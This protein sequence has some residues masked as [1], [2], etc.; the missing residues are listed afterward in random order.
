MGAPLA[1]TTVVLLLVKSRSLAW[2]GYRLVRGTRPL[3]ATPGL[4][5]ARV[6]GSGTGGGFTLQ[7]SATRGGLFCVF[8]SAKAAVAFVEGSATLAEYARN[9]AELG[10][11]T[12][13]PYNCRGRWGGA[14][15][16]ASEPAPA[17][18]AVVAL[19]RASIHPLRAL[20]FWRHAPPAQRAVE[21]AVGC[22]LAVGLGEAPLLRQATVS[23]WDDVHAMDA[24]ARAGAHQQ[25][26]LAA[27][28]GRH[29]SESMFVRF[30][31]VGA[32]GLWKGRPLV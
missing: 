30:V 7:P 22:R 8:D 16:Q 14:N 6:L 32:Q 1:D 12:L 28:R 20:D 17:G 10:V 23:L 21:T 4:R 31:L 25:A 19:T 2:A 5:W 18:G 26:I 11:L 3:R 13:R 15:L 24:Y 9:A 29:F 27:Q